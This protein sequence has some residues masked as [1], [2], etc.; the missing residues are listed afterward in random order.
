MSPL[1]YEARLARSM[2]EDELLS[3][4]LDL[5]ELHGWW[6]YHVRNSRAGI[7]QG[8]VG[9]PDV[10]ALRGKRILVAE[11][12]RE[13]AE[14]TA[15]QLDW[16]ERFRTTGADPYLWRPSHYL[17]GRIGEVLGTLAMAA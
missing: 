9:F 1:T 15:C 5:L 13:L 7:V 4:V 17:S 10:I 12:K 6:A 3:R 8:Q 2:S 14:P 16:L 11:L